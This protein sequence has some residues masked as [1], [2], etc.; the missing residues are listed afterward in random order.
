MNDK[1]LLNVFLKVAIAEGVS[2]LVLLLVA[3]PLKYAMK[4]PEPVRIVGMAHGVLFVAFCILLLLATI[5]YKWSIK[6]AL[7]G[8]LLSF[9]PFGTFYLER[10]LKRENNNSI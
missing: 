2:F 10:I 3:M 8:F 5:K 4:M 9:L 1:K 7:I 6:T